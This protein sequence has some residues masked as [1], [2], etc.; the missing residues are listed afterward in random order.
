MIEFKNPK[1]ILF[2]LIL[3][4]ASVFS[5]IKIKE[6]S[7]Y[8]ASEAEL[9]QNF[10]ETREIILLQNN[11]EIYVEDSPTSR[12][13]VTLPN[14][15]MGIEELIYETGFDLSADKISNN[16]VF[17]NITGINYSAEVFVNEE[18]VSKLE[19]GQIPE[20]LEIPKHILTFDKKNKL[21]IK[22]IHEPDDINTIP[23]NKNFLCPESHGGIYRDVYLELVPISFIKINNKNY[24]FSDGLSS[25]EIKLDFEVHNFNTQTD[26]INVDD[27][28]FDLSYVL[29]DPSG[30]VVDNYT[31][32][33]VV[34]NGDLIKKTISREITLPKLWSPSQ[35]DVYKAKLSF[36]KNNS[37]I[38]K[39]ESTF[40]FYLLSKNDDELKLNGNNFQLRGSG[41]YNDSLTYANLI[42]FED[43]KRLLDKI[44]ST[45]F[46]SVRFKD[47]IPSPNSLKYCEEIGLL[48]LID[49]P[50]NS[51]PEDIAS[52]VTFIERA[53]RYA[54]KFHNYYKKF[55]AVAFFGL[56][57]SYLANSKDHSELIRQLAIE[58]NSQS[59]KIRYASFVGLQTE[60]I[61]GIDFY[62]IELYSKDNSKFINS[63]KNLSNSASSNYFISEINYAVFE[64]EFVGY[65]NPNTIEAQAKNIEDVIE[66]TQE[67]NLSGVFIKSLYDYKGSNS[68]L[69]SSYNPERIYTLGIL[70][71]NRNETNPSFQVVTSFL[72][73]QNKVRIPIGSKKEDRSL[74]FIIGALILSVFMGLLINSKRK[75]RED[76]SRALIRPYNF[77]ADIRDMRIISG[78]HTNILMIII[79][80]THALLLTNLLYYL[81]SNFLVEKFLIAFDS[82]Q[83]LNFVSKLAWNPEAALIYFSIFSVGLIILLSLIA[84]FSTVFIKTRVMLSSIYFTLIWA[85]L[86]LT[87]ILPLLLLLYK[88]LLFEIAN[89]FI[90]GFL[91]LYF[92][93]MLQRLLKG[94][95]IIFDV[96][97][98]KVYLYSI[99]LFVFIFGGTLFYYH[100]TESTIYYLINSYKQFFLI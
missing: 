75:F 8:P 28:Q 31:E 39:I 13:Q 32:S 60:Q 29:F 59:S 69:F 20:R 63:F 18:V 58:V 65:I 89:Y 68:S 11:W 80:L 98:V 56:G 2:L 62:G 87:L 71:Q 70:G 35:P 61:T 82:P 67:N 99:L 21:V 57:N 100:M 4:S 94:I 66:F 30:E 33:V 9:Y 53:K 26:T 7:N 36:S 76:A 52:D 45:G 22:V 83:L 95:Y 44:K 24:S 92:I 72:K 88:V 16:F 64:N 74:L 54:S 17:L 15:F 90:Y 19:F 73:D 97:A 96:P 6:L 48:V 91:A 40:S 84:K 5:Q 1:N 43:H 12:K 49:L 46:N 47:I 86:P 77:F 85:L 38:D 3:F 14:T 81:K 27:S 25:A 34:K 41:Y 55:N 50:L 51:I 42:S 93:W 37:V 78:I 10:S 23:V 79:V